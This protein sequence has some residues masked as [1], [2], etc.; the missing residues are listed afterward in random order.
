MISLMLFFLPFDFLDTGIL[1]IKKHLAA[2]GRQCHDEANLSS[3][4]AFSKIHLLKAHHIVAT[5]LTVPPDPILAL[6]PQHYLKPLP[7]RCQRQEIELK[8]TIMSKL[9]L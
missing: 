6:T 5:K 9:I 1:L 3:F 4:I 2:G 8:K 7:N